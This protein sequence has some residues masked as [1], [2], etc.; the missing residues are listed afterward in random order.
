MLPRS[1]LMI[2]KRNW[3]ILSRKFVRIVRIFVKIEHIKGR[4]V[5][6][7]LE[8]NGSIIPTLWS[9]HNFGQNSWPKLGPLHGMGNTDPILSS[10]NMTSWLLTCFISTNVIMILANFP[11]I[12]IQ[13]FWKSSVI[14]MATLASSNHGWL[15]HL[16]NLSH[17]SLH[18]LLSAGSPSS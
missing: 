15:K 16:E 17:W 11:D 14:T 5:T 12:I 9:G 13:L 7:W 8:R 3:I 6:F 10:P 2:F 1:Q 4:W 18:L